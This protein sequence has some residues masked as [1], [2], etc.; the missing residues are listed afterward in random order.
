MCITLFTWYINEKIYKKSWA[1][2][3]FLFILCLA[4]AMNGRF[5]SSDYLLITKCYVSTSVDGSTTIE[6]KSIDDG[7]VWVPTTN[8]WGQYIKFFFDEEVYLSA[9]LTKVSI[10]WIVGKGKRNVYSHDGVFTYVH[11]S[12]KEYVHVFAML[13]LY[14][15]YPNSGEMGVLLILDTV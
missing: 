13:S 10:N 15:Q 4:V 12:V 8:L 6:M 9:V 2:S 14:T 11:V 3:S 5:R 7:V 1:F